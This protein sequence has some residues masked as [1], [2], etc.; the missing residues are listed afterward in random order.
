MPMHRTS[1]FNLVAPLVALI[2]VAASSRPAAACGTTIDWN[3][4][5]CTCRYSILHKECTL[6]TRDRE[7]PPSSGRVEVVMLKART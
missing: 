6:V 2:L 4:D 3:R 1:R 5:C 7:Q